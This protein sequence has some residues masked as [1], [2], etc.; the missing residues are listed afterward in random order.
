MRKLLL[1]ILGIGLLLTDVRFGVAQAPERWGPGDEAGASNTQTP[2]KVLE[3]VELI[4][5]GKVYRLGHEYNATMP[6]FPGR[7]GWDQVFF[8]P[9][10]AGHNVFNNEYLNLTEWAQLGTQFD[11][12]GHAAF[13]PE[14]FGDPVSATYYNGFTHEQVWTRNG[15][16]KLGVEK[17]KPYFTRGILLDCRRFLNNGQMM[18]EGQ[19][20]SRADI[21][22]VL[23]EEGLDGIRRGD[24]VL[25]YFGWE[26]LWDADP[27]RYYAGAPGLS[28][29]AARYLAE[30]N[31]GVV[32]S[33][34]WGIDA[35]P[36]PRGT[37]LNVFAPI[38]YEL[39]VKNGIP[40]QEAMKLGELAHDQVYEFAYIYVPV[41]ATGASGSPGSPIAVK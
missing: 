1:T 39:I 15:L 12:L 22:R 33:D 2:R 21:Q 41:P 5:H 26:D 7:H 27:N 38:H 35:I 24:A 40:Q 3:A 30:Q 19:T 16:V 28:V 32:G 29:D 31:V 36:P 14:A 6:Q 9:D 10:R 34:N 20:V 18:I 8:D 13:N 4:R 23:R 37:P 25:F 17:I 11:A